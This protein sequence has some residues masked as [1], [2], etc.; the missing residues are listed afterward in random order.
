MSDLF[1]AVLGHLN[2]WFF[3]PVNKADVGKGNVILFHHFREGIEGNQGTEH[4]LAWAKGDFSLSFSDF[5][6]IL[7]KETAV[8]FK[9]NLS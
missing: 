6:W 4:H 9:P 8:S 5:I 2:L 3:C 7:Q 1:R